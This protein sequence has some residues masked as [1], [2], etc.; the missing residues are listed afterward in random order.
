MIRQR[1]RKYLFLRAGA[2]ISIHTAIF[3]ARCISTGL[4]RGQTWEYATRASVYRNVGFIAHIAT[5]LVLASAFWT[6]F[7]T[8]PRFAGLLTGA[9]IL[10]NRTALVTATQITQ[11]IAFLFTAMLTL[12]MLG[13]FVKDF[14]AR[15]WYATMASLALAIAAVEMSALVGATIVVVLALVYRQLRERWPSVRDQMSLLLKGAGV[16]VAVL[17]IVW[18]AGIYKLSVARGFLFLAY[19]A[20]ERKTFSPNSPLQLWQMKFTASPWEHWFML[21][22]FVAAVVLWRRLDHR[23]EAL[24]WLVYG[25][26]FVL[27]TLKVTLEFTHYRGTIAAV[28]VM[29]AGIA[30]G[31]L[32]KYSGTVVRAA[33][34][35]VAVLCIVMQTIGYR[36]E[37]AVRSDEA[38]S[39]EQVLNFLRE[40]PVPPGKTLYVP[41]Y[42]I[43]TLHFYHP[44]LNAVGYDVDWPVTRL[45]NAIQ[46]EDAHREILCSE[47]IC[48]TVEAAMGG[49]LVRTPVAP[50]P[51]GQ[52]LYALKTGE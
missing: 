20:L 36:A 21:A 51:D 18:P 15:Y 10:F 3:T 42:L 24:P 50:S 26:V 40:R 49:N 34:A 52:R 19:M 12:W 11:H 48:R 30:I 37:A 45:L 6:L 32:W 23:R 13:L 14:K 46:A 27:A 9:A 17:F 31:H 39:A 2:A 33:V 16:L 5:A 4:Q 43:P 44:D 28:W 25:V 8:L 41:F 22:G 47:E 29:A 38:T 1:E 35:A 7:P